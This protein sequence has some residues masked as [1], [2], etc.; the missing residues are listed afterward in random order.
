L[1]YIA[2]EA[3]SVPSVSDHSQSPVAVETR[4]IDYVPSS[5]R[6]GKAWHLAPVWFVGNAN[7]LSFA[8]GA[9]GI[10]LGLNVAWT[11]VAAVVGLAIGTLMMAYHS[12]Q[13]PKLGLPQM[14]QSRPQFGYYGSI[15]PLVAAM[16]VFIGWNVFDVVISGQAL[17][18]TIKTP[19]DLGE[20]IAVVLSAALTIFGYELIHRYSRWT[21]Y[22]FI[23]VYGLLII[24]MFGSVHLPA[25][26]LVLS[27]AKFHGVAFLTVIGVMV[28]FQL[29]WAP[30]VSDYS[31]YLPK[32]TKA[33][34]TIGWTY[35]G[36]YLGVFWPLALGA[37]VSAAFP[38]ALTINAV[39]NVGNHLFPGYGTIVLL[40]S[41]PVLIAS[42]GIGIYSGGLTALAGVDLFSELR[43]NRR[44]RI[45]A[46]VLV[47]A[48][49]LVLALI[50]PSNFI[51]SFTAFLTTVLYFM[52]PWTAINLTDFYFVRKERYALRD[53]FARD[54]I[55]GLWNPRGIA[56]YVIGFCVMIPFFSVSFYTGP[57]ARA[58]GGADISPFVGFPVAAILYYLA[59]RKVDLRPEWAVAQQQEAELDA[60]G[61]T[62]TVAPR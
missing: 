27:S 28:S 8:S 12:A 7:L 44:D 45:V 15:I 36:S 52:I 56:C 39:R 10:S 43:K 59:Y 26:S 29:T 25:N 1:V 11:L 37:F 35:L 30:Y 41:I 17:Q 2:E 6:H 40:C 22:L 61:V 42:M 5:E 48:C 14:I 34:A 58:L 24:A 47:S 60:T 32:K 19:L 33:L 20:I 13:G 3:M 16:V 57:A 50:V 38:S 51:P 46:M 9:V 54:G 53:I 21:T 49:M 62:P 18:A 31:R 23:I 4:S 55:Y